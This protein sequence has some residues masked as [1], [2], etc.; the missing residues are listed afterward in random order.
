M[1]PGGANLPAKSGAGVYEFRQRFRAPL[2]FVFRWCTDYSPEDAA[3]EKEEYT[4]RVLRRS[5]REVVYEDLSESPDGWFWS[6][7]TVRLTPPGRWHADMQGNYRSWSAD[8]TLRALP[9]GS[10][11]LKFRGTRRPFLLATR[12]P[13]RRRLESELKQTWTRFA[14]ALEKEYR[15]GRHRPGK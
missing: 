2:P 3:L 11:E 6:R 1:R 9:D 8:Y 15:A 5:P 14:R 4:R 7:A 13:P 10:T 12:N